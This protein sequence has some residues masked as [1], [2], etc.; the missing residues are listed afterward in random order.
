ME[1][2]P[3]RTIPSGW[4]SGSRVITKRPSKRSPKRPKSK[5]R[6][7]SVR[8]NY[9][10]RG[11]HVASRDAVR[12]PEQSRR[13]FIRSLARTAAVFAFDDLVSGLTLPVQFVNVAREAGLNRKTIFGGEA[14]NRYLLETTGCGAA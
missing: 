13:A 1:P 6:P 8:P 5:R 14:H 10:K 12:H 2:T 4:F 3:G 9:C 7:K 11:P